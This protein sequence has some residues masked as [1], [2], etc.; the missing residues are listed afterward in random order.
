MDPAGESAAA[1]P[2]DPHVLQHGHVRQQAEALVHDGDAVPPALPA[3]GP[4]AAAATPSTET[5]APGSGVYSPV[6][7]FASVDLPEPF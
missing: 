4:G 1:Q 2:A 6:R 7:T 5:R 3:G